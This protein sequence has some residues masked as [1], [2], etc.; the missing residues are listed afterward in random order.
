MNEYLLA[1][2]NRVA[3]AAH[4]EDLVVTVIRQVGRSSVTTHDFNTSEERRQL[5]AILEGKDADKLTLR[6]IAEKVYGTAD[7]AVMARLRSSLRYG[8]AFQKTLIN[9]MLAEVRPDGTMRISRTADEFGERT[10]EF[11]AAAEARLIKQQKQGIIRLNRTIDA[12]VEKVPELKG[13]LEQTR[14]ET[15]TILGSAVARHLEL[16]SGED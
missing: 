6:T 9:G 7:D 16:L 8:S 10:D 12:A 2:D 11:L 14:Q 13:R 15:R 5:A 1:D 3:I 4:N